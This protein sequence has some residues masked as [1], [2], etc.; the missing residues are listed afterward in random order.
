MATSFGN[1]SKFLFAV[2]FCG[3]Q[4][5]TT[6]VKQTF[7]SSRFME[8]N[9]EKFKSMKSARMKLINTHLHISIYEIMIFV[10]N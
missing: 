8:M 2:T 3:E 7:S 1:I 9:N 10:K 5:N 6:V 4:T